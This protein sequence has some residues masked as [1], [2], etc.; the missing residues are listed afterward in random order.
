MRAGR[1]FDGRDARRP[2]RSRSSTRRWR[3]ISRRRSPVAADRPR[4]KGTGDRRGGGRRPGPPGF[5]QRGPLAAMP[6]A[7]IPLTQ[8][9]D[10]L[11]RLV[12]GWFATALMCARRPPVEGG[13]RRSLPQCCRPRDP[14][15]PFASS[16]VDGGGPGG[17]GG[18]APAPDGA[19]T[20]PRRRRYRT[21]RPRHP[22]TDR[23]IRYRAHARNRNP[24]GAGGLRLARRPHPWQCRESRSRRSASGWDHSAPASASGC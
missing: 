4:G 6:L 18:A 2:L 3:A 21:H 17:R 7:Y 16:A 24:D 23:R 8:A 20:R 5:G 12:H 14:L 9:G 13:G 19:P 22:R 1:R 15:L 11:L 10:G